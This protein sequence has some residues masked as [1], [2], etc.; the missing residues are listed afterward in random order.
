MQT[1]TLTCDRCKD[2]IVDKDP[3]FY[4]PKE[5][6]LPEGHENLNAFE[7][8]KLVQD[9]QADTYD[10]CYDCYIVMRDMVTRGI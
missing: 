1:V 2:S 7:K 3:C 10:L 6:K 8:L 4:M 5:I 9:F